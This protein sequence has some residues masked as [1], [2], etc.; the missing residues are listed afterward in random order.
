MIGPGVDFW[1]MRRRGVPWDHRR[2]RAMDRVLRRSYNPGLLDRLR[3]RLAHAI[4]FWTGLAVLIAPPSQPIPLAFFDW[5]RSATKSYDTDFTLELL[6]G[7]HLRLNGNTLNNPELIAEWRLFRY[8]V[9][10]LP[11]TENPDHAEGQTE[12]LVAGS[13]RLLVR[14]LKGEQVE[15][16][17]F[18]RL[19]AE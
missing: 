6:P 19:S 15:V 16:F 4:D 1:E 11:V 17:T 2:L 13:E 14:Y 3:K 10:R 18:V 9:T 5:L 7:S 12:I 8:I